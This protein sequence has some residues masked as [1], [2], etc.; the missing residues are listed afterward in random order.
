[1][2]AQLQGTS[3]VKANLN[4]ATLIGADLTDTIFSTAN[5]REA[6]LRSAVHLLPEQ[7]QTA[8]QWEMASYDV[9]MQEQL[10][11]IARPEPS[12]SH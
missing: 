11:L 7:V 6:D 3:F 9:E 5:L 8:N 1:V 4:A 2:L 10:G 12:E